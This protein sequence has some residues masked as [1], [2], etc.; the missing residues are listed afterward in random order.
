MLSIKD[1][2]EDTPEAQ[3][4]E[5]NTK[6]KKK[7]KLDVWSYTGDEH[8]RVYKKNLSHEEQLEENEATRKRVNHERKRIRDRVNN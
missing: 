6:E 7:K 8:L 1:L 4:A 2:E 5:E 3:Q